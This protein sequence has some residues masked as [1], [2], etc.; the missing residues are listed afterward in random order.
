[1][2][3]TTEKLFNTLVSGNKEDIKLSFGNALKDKLED[4]LEIKKINLADNVFNR[5]MVEESTDL[6][7]AK[8]EEPESKKDLVDLLKKAKQV[9]GVTDDE[10]MSWYGNMDDKLFSEWDKMVKKDS[11]YKKAYKLGYD[12]GSDKN[13][14]KSGTLAAAIWDD[15]YAAGAMDS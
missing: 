15:Q 13:P 1:M 5:A 3:S 7:E 6:T 2:N 4:A 9:R 12:G 14:H 10:Y 11:N 8:L